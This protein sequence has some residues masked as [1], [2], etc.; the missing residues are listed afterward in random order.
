MSLS[1]Q[2]TFRIFSERWFNTDGPCLGL[3]DPA[4]SAAQLGWPSLL[5]PPRAQ[6][7]NCSVPSYLHFWLNGKNVL[8]SSVFC[9]SRLGFNAGLARQTHQLF[10]MCPET[11]DFIR[12]KACFYDAK[13][14]AL[15]VNAN[16][17]L[18]W[19]VFSD[20]QFALHVGFCQINVLTVEKKIRNPWPTIKSLLSRARVRVFSMSITFLVLKVSNPAS[21]KCL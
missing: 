5:D 12:L 18:L 11:L 10:V 1:P 9:Q 8:P 2:Q 20:A 21:K 13:E 6:S 14:H 16:R 15:L 19:I 4:C 17:V 7:H 3:S